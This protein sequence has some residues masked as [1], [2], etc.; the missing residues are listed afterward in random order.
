[1]AGRFQTV[2]DIYAKGEKVETMEA[3]QQQFKFLKKQMTE[4]DIPPIFGIGITNETARYMTSDLGFMNIIV[5]MG[6][7]GFLFIIFVFVYLFTRSRFLVYRARDNLH[8]LVG[9]AVLCMLP[10]LLVIG[11]NFDYLTGIHF[12]L[13]AFPILLIE[14]ATFADRRQTEY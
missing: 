12:I 13:L 10:G 14:A 1:M 6:L 7:A 8:K 9:I 2:I 3:R 5:N 4:A 11:Y